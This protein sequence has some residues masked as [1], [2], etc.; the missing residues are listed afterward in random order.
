MRRDHIFYVLP[1]WGALLTPDTERI[2][3]LLKGTPGVVSLDYTDV[4]Y[5]GQ[6]WLTYEDSIVTQSRLSAVL[7]AAGYKIMRPIHLGVFVEE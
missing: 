5:P 3:R 7:K 2:R 6:I 4:G 1:S